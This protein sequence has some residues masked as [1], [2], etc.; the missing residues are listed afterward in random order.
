MSRDGDYFQDFHFTVELLQEQPE[1]FSLHI[2][3]YMNF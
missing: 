3:Q 1:K 2:C